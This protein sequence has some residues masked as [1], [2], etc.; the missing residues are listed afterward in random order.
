MIRKSMASGDDPMV[1]TGLASR[2]TQNAFARRSC[3]N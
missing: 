3:S 1:N 2:Q